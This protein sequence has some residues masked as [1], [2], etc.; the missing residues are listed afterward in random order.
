[1]DVKWENKHEFLSLPLDAL[2]KFN[3]TAKGKQVR[4]DTTG[5]LGK[6]FT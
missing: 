1:M 3:T 4:P 6:Q 5:N 2:D